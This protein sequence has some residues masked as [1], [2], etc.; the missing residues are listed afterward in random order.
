M[1]PNNSQHFCGPPSTI[2]QVVEAGDSVPSSMPPLSTPGQSN[3]EE[4][5]SRLF[6]AFV[7]SVKEEAHVQAQPRLGFS[8][9]AHPQ[10]STPA[11]TGN[12]VFRRDVK[13]PPNTVI[14]RA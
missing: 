5:I 14:Q 4:R 10:P 9:A 7:S 2:Y 12:P 1:P 8:L 13:S 6:P 3:R 11:T